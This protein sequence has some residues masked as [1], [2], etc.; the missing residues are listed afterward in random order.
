MKSPEFMRSRTVAV[1]PP[2][3]CPPR[4][5]HRC[6]SSFGESFLAI[7]DVA[8]L[9]G[10]LLDVAEHAHASEWNI[11]G[12]KVIGRLNWSRRRCR[13]PAGFIPGHTR[14]RGAVYPSPSIGI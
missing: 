7:I 8:V 4:G 3:W 5:F 10:A 14:G 1:Y 9:A 13:V 2:L 6:A 11:F 12:H